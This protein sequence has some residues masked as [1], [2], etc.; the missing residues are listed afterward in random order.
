MFFRGVFEELKWFLNGKC[1]VSIL[2]DKQ[3]Y[4]WKDNSKRETLDKLGFV[5]RKE[6]DAGPIYPH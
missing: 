4:I 1:D 2:N 3:V 6:Y 5:D